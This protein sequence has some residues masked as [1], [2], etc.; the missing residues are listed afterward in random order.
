[1]APEDM[2]TKLVVTGARSSAKVVN[3]LPRG[4]IYLMDDTTEHVGNDEVS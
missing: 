1:M 2:E 4:A 3:V